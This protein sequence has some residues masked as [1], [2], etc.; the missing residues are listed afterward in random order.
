MKKILLMT[1]IAVFSISSYAQLQFGGQIG[2]NLGLGH[3]TD[4]YVDPIYGGINVANDPKVGFL[5]GVL[6]EVGF[7]KLAFRPELNFV[8]KGSKSGYNGLGSSADKLTLN[9]IEVPLNVVYNIKLSKLGKVFFGLGPAIGIGLSGK[10]K[11]IDVDDN[12]NAITV[13][14]DIKFDG[15]KNS[16]DNKLH[17]KRTD[18]GANILA[19]FQLPMGVF[20]KLGFTYGFSNIDPY[21]DY[22]YKNRCFNICVGY[23]IGKK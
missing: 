20:A 5:I 16:T 11:Y 17:Y 21:T 10:D 2:A 19:G 3:A 1:A 13:K 8:Q 15:D 14:E 9:Y 22:K 7:G 6:G 4:Q 23:I 12:G 18:I